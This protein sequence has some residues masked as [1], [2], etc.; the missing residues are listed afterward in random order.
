MFQIFLEV[1]ILLLWI[2]VTVLATLHDVVPQEF[3]S[4]QVL[5]G[6]LA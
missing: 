4:Y 2:V 5:L 3:L 6:K 1:S